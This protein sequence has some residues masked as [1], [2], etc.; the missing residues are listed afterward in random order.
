MDNSN[1]QE[2]QESERQVAVDSPGQAQDAESAALDKCRQDAWNDFDK[3][4][5]IKRDSNGVSVDDN[6]LPKF[7]SLY[8]NEKGEISMD[9]VPKGPGDPALLNGPKPDAVAKDIL[10]WVEEQEKNGGMKQEELAEKVINFAKFAMNY[11]QAQEH[12]DP[13]AASDNYHKTDSVFG[14]IQR[15]LDGCNMMKVLPY[16][17]S[18]FMLRE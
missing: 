9:G 15:K 8:D 6:G 2:K 1:H 5:G 13:Q 3:K 10:N 12:V 17:P 7:E 14:E 16:M 18:V 4:Q 11:L